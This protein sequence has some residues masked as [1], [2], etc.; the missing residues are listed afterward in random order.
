MDH[1]SF[2]K[3]KDIKNIVILVLLLGVLTLGYISLFR[4]DKLYEYK[5]EE[6]KKQNEALMK[7]K[8][9]VDEENKTLRLEFSNLKA[10]EVELIKDINLRDLEIQKS[11]DN[12][13]RSKRELEKFKRDIEETRRKIDSLKSNPPNRT[14]DDLLNSI[15]LKTQK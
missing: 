11:K 15:K 7:Q 6:L 1:Q 8:L 5:V 9:A 10:K 13:N 2:N 3:M 4:G 12:A 14:G